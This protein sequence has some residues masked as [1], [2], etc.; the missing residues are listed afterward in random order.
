MPSVVDKDITQMTTGDGTTEQVAGA[1]VI[2]DE[3]SARDEENIHVYQYSYVGETSRP[4]RE[5]VAEHMRSLR[6]GDIRSFQ[7]NHWYEKHNTSISAPEFKWTVLDKYDDALRRQLCEG[8]YIMQSGSLN[9]KAEFNRNII[10]R[11]EATVDNHMTDQQL[12]QEVN[13]RKNYNEKLKCFVN[14]MSTL[15]DDIKLAKGGGVL[16]GHRMLKILSL[17]D[18]RHSL[19]RQEKEKSV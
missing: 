17:P 6:N 3:L 4:L 18:I 12:K 2:T 14:K 9:K 16:H 5:R 11:L 19:W 1:G 13:D 8:L 10:C 15:S 7:I